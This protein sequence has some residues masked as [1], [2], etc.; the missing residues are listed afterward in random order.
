MIGYV[1][2]VF[3]VTQEATFIPQRLGERAPAE[4]RRV[5]G[6]LIVR[7]M[8]HGYALLETGAPQGCRKLAIPSEHRSSAMMIACMA[9]RHHLSAG[10]DQQ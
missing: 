9:E 4:T 7:Q 3:D 8:V 5:R 2:Y 6:C 10:P 1:F